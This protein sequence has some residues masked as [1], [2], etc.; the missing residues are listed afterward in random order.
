MST[1]KWILTFN[2]DN[3][4]ETEASGCGP[5]TAVFGVHANNV[6]SM[7][8]FNLSVD[9]PTLTGVT[10]DHILYVDINS[11]ISTNDR[12]FFTIKNVYTGNNTIEV[13]EST[14]IQAN[15]LTWA[16]GGKRKNPFAGQNDYQY[17][18]RHT[19]NSSILLDWYN[20]EI[21]PSTASYDITSNK[22]SI[23]ATGNTTE[24][25]NLR[26][27]YG[28]VV[29][30]GTSSTNKSKLQGAGGGFTEPL[31]NLDNSNRG[32]ILRNLE[33]IVVNGYASAIADLGN[34]SDSEF[35]FIDCDFVF[36]GAIQTDV[37]SRNGLSLIGNQPKGPIFFIGCNFYS[38]DPGSNKIMNYGIYSD[39]SASSDEEIVVLECS[40]R[41]CEV[42]AY[43]SEF[44][45]SFVFLNNLIYGCGFTHPNKLSSAIPS[46]ANNAIVI[47]HSTTFNVNDPLNNLIIKN[48][49]IIGAEKNGI[50]QDGKGLVETLNDDIQMSGIIMNNN[51][52]DCGDYAFRNNSLSANV[53][54]GIL[55]TDNNLYNN[56][57]GDIDTT[58]TRNY[59]IKDN[60]NV[61]PNFENSSVNNYVPGDTL[62]NKSIPSNYEDTNTTNYQYIGA[63]NA[64]EKEGG[65]PPKLIRPPIINIVPG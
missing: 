38:S 8:K 53:A 10:T 56:G 42:A 7:T 1:E 17:L 13:N 35:M 29:I 14:S 41:D 61:N 5:A 59:Y 2:N 27:N 63:L 32:L 28:P 36:N 37:N 9:S 44:T 51:I 65:S 39:S 16:V 57:L 54:Q 18:M 19:S 33:C 20:F 11:A 31:W 21:E 26:K 40:F 48:N 15:S 34:D 55:F 24:G 3:G 52:V 45:N 23:K 49:T 4:S 43:V 62:K 64:S 58:Y 25:R 22:I 6:D 12:K 60:I 47:R 50:F 30:A 46:N